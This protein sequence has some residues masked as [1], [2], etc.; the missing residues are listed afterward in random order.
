MRCAAGLLEKLQ[1]AAMTLEEVNR[2]LMAY[3]DHKRLYFP[4]FFFLSNDDLLDILSESNDPA[5]FEPHCK[6]LFQ[7]VAKVP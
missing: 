4:R 1:D 2:G 5:R 6:K 7:G 3:L